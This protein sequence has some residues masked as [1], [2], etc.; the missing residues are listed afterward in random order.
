[1]IVPIES[2]IGLPAERKFKPETNM[3]FMPSPYYCVSVTKYEGRK[4]ICYK[5]PIPYRFFVNSKSAVISYAVTWEKILLTLK[6][7]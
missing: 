7:R 3:D 2:Y 5:D 1:M 4:W 6:R